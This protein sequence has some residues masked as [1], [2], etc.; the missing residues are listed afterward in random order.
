MKLPLIRLGA[1]VQRMVTVLPF[2]YILSLILPR[3]WFLYAVGANSACNWASEAGYWLL[4]YLLQQS[5]LISFSVNI[6]Q[7]LIIFPYPLTK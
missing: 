7:C 6:L 5:L 3:L 2:L 1:F 4:V